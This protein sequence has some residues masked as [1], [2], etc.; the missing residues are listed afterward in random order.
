MISKICT[1]LLV[2]VILQDGVSNLEGGAERYFLYLA[3]TDPELR[4]GTGEL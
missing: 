3:T 4:Y 1:T 2:R